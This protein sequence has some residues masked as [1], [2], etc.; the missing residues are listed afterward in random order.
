MEDED[1]WEDLSDYVDSYEA[2]LAKEFNRSVAPVH[3]L[4]IDRQEDCF[5]REDW[6]D[7]ILVE[8]E[9]YE[10]LTPEEIAQ[11]AAIVAEMRQ[12]EIIESIRLKRVIDAVGGD[13]AKL[14]GPN[15]IPRDI[16]PYA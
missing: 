4:D 5:D 1:D 3:G 13:P 11:S 9:L 10:E 14:I 8:P 6:E 15:G 12:V 7:E 2:A 16:P